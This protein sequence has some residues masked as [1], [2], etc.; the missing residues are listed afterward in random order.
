VT[1]GC[2]RSLRPD[3]PAAV[4]PGHP[5]SI[6]IEC[7]RGVAI[8][9]VFCF[10]VDLFVMQRFFTPA[11]VVSPGVAFVRGGYTGV[12][13]FFVISGF[14]LGG[15]FLAEMTGG[16]PVGRREYARRRALRILPLYYSMV[17]LGSVLAAHAPMDVLRGLPYL[18]FLNAFP[19]FAPSLGSFSGVWWSLA[20]EVQFY[21]LLPVIALLLR[22]WALRKVALGGLVAYGA[23]YVALAGGYPWP[24]TVESRSFLAHS[25]F[26]QGPLFCFGWLAAGIHQRFG[27]RLRQSAWARR[28]VADGMLLIALLGIALLLR[29]TLMVGQFRDLTTELIWHVPEGLLWA[30]VLLLVLTPLRLKPVFQNRALAWVGTISYALYLIHVPVIAALGGAVRSYAPGAL[31]GWSGSTALLVT[32]LTA[33]CFAVAWLAHVVIERPVLAPQ[34]ARVSRRGGRLSG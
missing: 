33:V 32:A 11:G 23:A 31:V 22:P 29:W 19:R 13:L 26:G 20:T 9:L 34:S 21:V 12:S 30:I 10:H 4:A 17:A 8:L 14:L 1:L 7:L 18:A 3:A 27:S 24:T 6:E 5:Y 28:G 25:A 16:A 2:A 15:Q